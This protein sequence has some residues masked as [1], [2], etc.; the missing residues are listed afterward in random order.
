M[1]SSMKTEAKRKRPAGGDTPKG[2]A[3]KRPAG[4]GP[5]AAKPAPKAA[6]KLLSKKEQK[7]VVKSKKLKFKKNYATIQETVVLWEQLRPKQATK[8][9]KAA[10]VSRILK[11][12]QGNT[13]ELA[14]H[15]SASRVIQWCLKEGG[16]AERARLQAEI[17]AAVVPLSKSK[18]GRHVVQKLI[19]L[20][21]KEDVPGLVKLFR[22]HV[23]ELLRHPA[24]AD[25]LD[26]LYSVAPPPCRN[27]LCAELYAREFSLFG[28]VAMPA[29]SIAHLGQLLAGAEPAK[30]AAVVAHLYKGLAPV[31]E[32]AL[33]HPVMT[34]R[35]LREL[36]TEAPGSLVADVV[37][38]LA[39]TG[40]NA[41]KL[42]HTHDGAAAACM[43]LAYGTPKDRKRLVKGMKGFVWQT[44]E[45]EWGHAVVATA[46]TVVDDTALTS[47]TIVSELREHLEELATNKHAHRVLMQLLAPDCHRYLPPATLELLH[48]PAKSRMVPESGPRE[49]GAAPDGDDEELDE[50]EEDEGEAAAEAGDG[51]G[52]DGEAAAN[53]G[54]A[55]KLVERPLG[56]S[57]KAA[58][59]RRRELL[60]GGKDC[61][62]AAL[63]AL[64][65]GQ[66]GELLRS[67]VGGDVVV[68]V[69]R[70]G[71]GG[72]LW[73]L[74]QGGVE[75]VHA[76]IVAAVAADCSG[77]GAPQQ[78][79][80]QGAKKKK[81]KAEAAAEQAP[82]Q[83]PEQQEGLLTHYHAS[84]ALRRL[85]LAGG[86]D[87]ADGAGA[88]AFAAALWSRALAGRC[89][90]LVGSH[91]E[92]VL[93]GLLHCGAPDV[94]A[95]AAAELAP[96][97]GGDAAAW[98]AR[99][100]GPPPAGGAAAPGGSKDKAKKKA[101]QQ[102]R[103]R[104]QQE[105]QQEQPH[106]LHSADDACA[107]LATKGLSVLEV[108][109]E[110][111]GPCKSTVTLFKTIRQDKDDKSALAFLTNGQLRA[112]I[113]GADVPA[114]SSSIYELTPVHPELD[115][116][117][118]N[119]FHLARCEGREGKPGN[120]RQGK[121]APGK[122]R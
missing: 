102:Q 44:A 71:A 112:R 21:P 19:A 59:A 101:K 30:R 104:Q 88:R 64:C 116:L 65:A 61:L 121:A 28:G 48:P 51:S 2:P 16:A 50:E 6:P 49:S 110:W 24:G 8:E 11:K 42:V 40:G 20:A 94:E 92:K 27:A 76:A 74:Q 115:D 103:Q 78:P 67:P 57:K 7:E 96:L 25:V 86:A 87:G 90:P 108:H 79:Q 91:A 31:L 12:L 53:G 70:G 99:F 66:A 117:A 98:A 60:G 118:E 106:A 63:C 89:A 109:A 100:M 68:E 9:E 58:D 1:G 77:S 93:A 35:L 46:L 39:A 84:R 80:P 69:S 13:V 45:N 18:F 33:L 55:P 32:K 56:E 75:G 122:K 47:K 23:A 85:L 82:E 83:A 38:T 73:E 26:D 95:A 97:V 34:H 114:L 22:G 3:S 107:A 113:V 111:C 15:H 17:R 52:S 14:N 81:A 36:L 4:K 10:L 41:L 43:A 119:P 105:Q 54:A 5:P 72:L 37:D 120:A 29:E 62:A